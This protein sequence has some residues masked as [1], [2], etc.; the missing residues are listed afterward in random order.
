[1]NA[2]EDAMQM[3]KIM[4]SKHPRKTRCHIVRIYFDLALSVSQPR[5]R[6]LGWNIIANAWTNIINRHTRYSN[7][8][9]SYRYPIGNNARIPT[10]KRN[11][12][13]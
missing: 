13:V 12:P 10:S 8:T 9:Q 3:R 11:A 4:E 6:K 5:Y 1:M 2:N 7:T